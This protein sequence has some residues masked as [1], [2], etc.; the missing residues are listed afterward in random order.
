[1]EGLLARWALA[2]QEYEFNIQYKRGK[3]NGNADAL[4]RKTYPDTQMV[5]ATSQTLVL[6]EIMKFSASSRLL[7][8][9]SM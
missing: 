4:S 9:S 6:N 1:M 2:I 3:D 7:T 5:A 8:E